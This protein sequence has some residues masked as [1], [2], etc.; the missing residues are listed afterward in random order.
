MT[1]ARRDGNDTPFSRWLRE[2][3]ALDSHSSRTCV[4]DVDYWI[5]KYRCTHDTRG[6]RAVDHL[7]LVELKTR[8]RRVDFAQRDTLGLVRRLIESV[9]LIGDSERVMTKRIM[10]GNEPREVKFYGY[11][12]LEI[13]GDRPDTSRSIRWHGR[14]IDLDVLIEVLDFA[15]HPRTLRRNV[16]RRHQPPGPKQLHKDLFIDLE[17]RLISVPQKDESPSRGSLSGALTP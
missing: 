16:D 11:F 7:M 5:H 12:A 15:V 17:T 10:M 14:E 4:Q 8:G 2:Q 13:S 6:D 3:P 1:A 9:F